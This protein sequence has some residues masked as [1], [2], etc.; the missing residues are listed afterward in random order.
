LRQQRKIAQVVITGDSIA[1]S[2]TFP[3]RRWMM[4]KVHVALDVLVAA[5]AGSYAVSY[6]STRA[7]YKRNLLQGLRFCALVLEHLMV[8]KVSLPTAQLPEGEVV[9]EYKDATN[10]IRS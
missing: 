3:T 6:Y 9:D 2:L 5:I 4:D 10:H 1:V 7:K 8:V